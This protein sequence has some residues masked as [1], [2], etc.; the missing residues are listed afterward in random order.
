[1]CENFLYGFKRRPSGGRCAAVLGRRTPD[2][3]R[4]RIAT[5]PA[6]RPHRPVH[7]LFPGATD[8]SFG[9]TQVVR[10]DLGT[11]VVETHGPVGASS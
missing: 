1:M 2:G 9:A 7:A 11:V 5:P 8:L 4:A 3:G 6:A 10:N